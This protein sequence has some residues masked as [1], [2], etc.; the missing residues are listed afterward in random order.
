MASLTKCKDRMLFG[1]CCGLAKALNMDVTMVRVGFVIGAL[2]TGSIL[3]WFYLLLALL[4]PSDN[5]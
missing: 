1:V 4:M 5:S 2:F 3:F